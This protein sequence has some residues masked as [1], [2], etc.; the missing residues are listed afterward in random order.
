M[1]VDPVQFSLSRAKWG[2]SKIFRAWAYS[3]QLITRRKLYE[4]F[5]A[6]YHILVLGL[7]RRGRSGLDGSGLFLLEWLLGTSSILCK[8]RGAFQ[9]FYVFYKFPSSL[10]ERSKFSQYFCHSLIK[11]YWIVLEVSNE[12]VFIRFHKIIL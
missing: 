10:F 8:G 2:S 6:K 4:Y 12:I 5:V 1:Q 3:E 11:L 9:L 7:C